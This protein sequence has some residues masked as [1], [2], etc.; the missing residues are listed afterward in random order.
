MIDFP[1]FKANYLNK[2]DKQEINIFPPNI[3]ALQR[4]MNR[5][6]VNNPAVQQVM[7]SNIEFDLMMMEVAGA[8]VFVG[9]ANYFNVPVVGISTVRSNIFVQTWTGTPVPAAY[10]PFVLSRFRGDMTF[11]ERVQNTLLQAAVD[12]IMQYFTFIGDVRNCLINF[13][14]KINA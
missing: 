14:I 6:I 13:F 2:T 12:V 9:F 8:D 3:T 5:L 11:F 7:R 4:E 1:G 10:L